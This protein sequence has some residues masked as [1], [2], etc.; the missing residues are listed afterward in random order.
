MKKADTVHIE[1]QKCT[2]LHV[3]KYDNIV[4]RFGLTALYFETPC[5]TNEKSCADHRKD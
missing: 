2:I 1:A 4:A 3:T 5:I